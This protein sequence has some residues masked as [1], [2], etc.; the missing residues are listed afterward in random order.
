MCIAVVSSVRENHILHDTVSG[1]NTLCINNTDDRV[2]VK[3]LH[4]S[5]PL[6]LLQTR[7]SIFTIIHSLAFSIFQR[8]AV[9]QSKIFALYITEL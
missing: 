4:I 8:A 9:H 1:D 3:E 5:I 7:S 6:D 2:V